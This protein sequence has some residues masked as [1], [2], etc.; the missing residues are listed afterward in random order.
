MKQATEEMLSP[1]EF[2]ERLR[3]CRQTVQT[4]MHRDEIPYFRVGR[5]YRIPLNRALRQLEEQSA[6]KYFTG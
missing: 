5:Q 3:V 2:A 1:Q 4:M 6:R